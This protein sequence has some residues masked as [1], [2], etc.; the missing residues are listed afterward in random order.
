M[1]AGYLCPGHTRVTALELFSVVPSSWKKIFNGFIMNRKHDVIDL[2]I[3]TQ[4]LIKACWSLCVRGQECLV[5]QSAS[6]RNWAQKTFSYVLS[7]QL[8]WNFCANGQL[9]LPILAS[10]LGSYP[11]GCTDSSWW[12]QVP[13]FSIQAP[14][15]IIWKQ[16]KWLIGKDV[17]HVLVVLRSIQM[18]IEEKSHQC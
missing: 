18:I 9:W 10:L 7:L 5:M 14:K 1:L 16:I 17:Y 12:S 6:A 2:K 15:L 4:M 3:K 8:Q 11:Q 13:K